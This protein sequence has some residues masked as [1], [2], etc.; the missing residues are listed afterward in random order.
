MKRCLNCNRECDDN[1]FFCPMCGTRLAEV[2]YE[3]NEIRETKSLAVC[4][5]VFAFVFPFVGVILSIIGLVKYKNKDNRTLVLIGIICGTVM[6]I[7][8]AIINMYYTKQILPEI[9]EFFEGVI[10]ESSSAI[11]Y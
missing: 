1:T 8:N 10:A 7:A 6:M 4:A 2:N 5:L 3:L 11:P 9:L